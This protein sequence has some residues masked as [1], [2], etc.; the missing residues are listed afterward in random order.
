M[1]NQNRCLGMMLFGTTWSRSKKKGHEHLFIILYTVSFS[2]LFF[3]IWFP[4]DLF[5]VNILLLQLPS[6]LLTKTTFHGFLSGNKFSLTT[7]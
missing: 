3:S 4:F 2:S 1:F 6:I 5:L 7:K